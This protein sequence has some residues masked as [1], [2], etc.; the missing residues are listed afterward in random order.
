MKY[1]EF[2]GSEPSVLQL[3]FFVENNAELYKDIDTSVISSY[4][5]FSNKFGGYYYIGGNIRAKLDER[6][7]YETLDAAENIN[8]NAEITHQ[9]EYFS[10]IRVRNELVN[11]RK[12]MDIY[13]EVKMAEHYAPPEYGAGEGY[14]AIAATTRIG[15]KEFSEN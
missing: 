1:P 9:M 12:I 13:Y 6:I 2:E 10:Q 8:E 15:K 5:D 7:L 11:L 4:I 14:N 3:L